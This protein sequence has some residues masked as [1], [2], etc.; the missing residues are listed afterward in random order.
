MKGFPTHS[1]RTMLWKQPKFA[2]DHFELRS[3]DELLGE[4]TWTKWL[5]DRALAKCNHG[6]WV[7][8]RLGFFRDQ[9]IATEAGSGNRV[10][11]FEF[12]WLGEGDVRLPNGQVFP[13]F[14]TKALC[15]AWALTNESGEPVF[16]IQFGMRWFKQEAVVSLR[17]AA[18]Q[19]PELGLLLCLGFYLG[20]M[21]LQ[22]AAGAAAATT[23]AIY[24]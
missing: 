3:G 11:G 21:S 7:L 16:E 19:T 4:I 24:G 9:V 8:D 5:S 23:A 14:R 18:D 17:P 6:T 20:Y 12:G 10:A 15:G 1:Q 22:D 13:W 2:V